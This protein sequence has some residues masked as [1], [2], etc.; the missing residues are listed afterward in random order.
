MIFFNAGMEICVEPQ[1]SNS[2]CD[3]VINDNKGT[4]I[5]PAIPSRT[6]AT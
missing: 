5:S 3:A 4:G 1:T 2:K 6:A